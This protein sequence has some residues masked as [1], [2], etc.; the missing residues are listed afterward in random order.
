M[1]HPNDREQ[2]FHEVIIESENVQ[3][4]AASVLDDVIQKL[5]KLSRDLREKGTFPIASQLDHDRDMERSH[6]SKIRR[7]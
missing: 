5:E 2:E 3:I 4:E 7:Q 1:S 6:G